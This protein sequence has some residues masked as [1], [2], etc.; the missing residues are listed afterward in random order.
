MSRIWKI[1]HLSNTGVSA[2]PGT[3]LPTGR[4]TAGPCLIYVAGKAALYTGRHRHRHTVAGKAAP[5]TGNTVAP[6]L[7]H[8]TS[9]G[10]Q[11][12]ERVTAL[13]GEAISPEKIN[14]SKFDF[15][16]TFW[17]DVTSAVTICLVIPLILKLVGFSKP[18]TLLI[19]PQGIPLHRGSHPSEISDICLQ[20]ESGD[21]NH[22]IDCFVVIGIDIDETAFKILSSSSHL[23]DA[24]LVLGSGS[25]PWISGL[26]AGGQA[27]WCAAC[28]F[29]YSGLNLKLSGSGRD[30]ITHG[31][32]IEMT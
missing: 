27:K 10:Q 14:F 2:G 23:E 22:N 26:G 29:I 31:L 17:I 6:A 9:A 19:F 7:N 30:R 25:R 21:S 16:Q 5:Y 1:S 28:H 3:P 8:P 18:E 4:S 11:L 13:L 24:H 20:Q 15:H 12:W 32:K